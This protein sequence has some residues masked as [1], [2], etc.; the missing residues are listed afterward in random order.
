MRMFFPCPGKGKKLFGQKPRALFVGAKPVGI[1]VGR[2]D[3]EIVQG[4]RA[5]HQRPPHKG[6]AGLVGRRSQLLCQGFCVKLTV[7]IH[8]QACH[9]RLKGLPVPS[10]PRQKP[11]VGKV[12]AV[13]P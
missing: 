10:K 4:R 11:V 5:L 9:G 8:N 2:L 6:A 3:E 12:N 1:H 13:T 7:G